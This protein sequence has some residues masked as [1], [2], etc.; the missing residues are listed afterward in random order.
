M[1]LNRVRPGITNWI[2]R[3]NCSRTLLEITFHEK[4]RQQF[5][6]DT[7]TGVVKKYLRQKFRN[8]LN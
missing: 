4:A 2:P 8:C 5:L 1:L 6:R 3:K 7:M